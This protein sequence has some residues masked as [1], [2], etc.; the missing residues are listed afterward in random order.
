MRLVDHDQHPAVTLGLLAS[1][2]VGG[3]P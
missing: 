2:Q 1:Q 3:L